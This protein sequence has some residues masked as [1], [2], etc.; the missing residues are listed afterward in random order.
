VKIKKLTKL[1][2]FDE[3]GLHFDALSNSVYDPS[4]LEYLKEN[5]GS[6]TYGIVEVEIVPKTV[7]V[8]RNTPFKD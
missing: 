2:Q 1:V 5:R 6:S 7:L 3:N 8:R 4:E